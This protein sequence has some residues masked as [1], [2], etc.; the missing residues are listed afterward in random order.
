M[1]RNINL[2]FSFTFDIPN[3][4]LIFKEAFVYYDNN[5]FPVKTYIRW[6]LYTRYPGSLF[7][8]YYLYK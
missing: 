5:I 6:T 2:C 4:Y 8:W 1:Y 7:I 3:C